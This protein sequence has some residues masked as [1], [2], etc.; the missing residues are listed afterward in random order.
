MSPLSHTRG[1][2]EL[3]QKNLTLTWFPC[4]CRCHSA[5][6]VHIAYEVGEG[7]QGKGFVYAVV[8][9][10]NF[11]KELIDGHPNIPFVRVFVVVQV[12]DRFHG[13]VVPRV[14]A[15]VRRFGFNK[16]HP[17]RDHGQIFPIKGVDNVRFNLRVE[18]VHRNVSRNAVAGKSP[19]KSSSREGGESKGK[20]SFHRFIIEV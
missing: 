13:A 2:L 20:E 6:L 10:F 5:G 17:V 12:V 16:V 3:S 18:V 4:P 14:Q 7:T 9:R 19:C 15:V 11:L 1:R 8:L